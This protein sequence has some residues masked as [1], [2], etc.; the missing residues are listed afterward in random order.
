MGLALKLEGRVSD[1]MKKQEPNVSCL[2]EIVT[3]CK[4]TNRLKVKE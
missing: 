3:N 1:W 4:D 2:Q